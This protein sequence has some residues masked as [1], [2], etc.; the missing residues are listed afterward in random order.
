[1]LNKTEKIDR[2]CDDVIDTM[3][4]MNT[5]LYNRISGLD[6]YLDDAPKLASAYESLSNSLLTLELLKKERETDNE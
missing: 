5:R 3:T 2:L 4:K 6:K 1:M